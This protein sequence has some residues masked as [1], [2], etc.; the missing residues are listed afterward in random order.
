MLCLRPDGNYPITLLN[1]MDISVHDNFL[2]CYEVCCERREVR[3]RTEYRDKGEPFEHTDVI[4]TGVCAYHFRH[5]C[6]GNIILDIEEIAP[7]NIYQDNRAQFE[8]GWRYG[9]P[10]DWGKT[11]EA[12]RA[13][14]R[15]HGVRGYVLSSSYGMDGWILGQKMGKISRDGQVA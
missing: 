7:E 9:W 12:A 1:R 10:G 15:E 2:V 3:V 14:F 13:Y 8:A 6:F 4:F 5:D 11:E